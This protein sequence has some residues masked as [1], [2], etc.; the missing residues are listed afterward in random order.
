MATPTLPP[1]PRPS[2]LG[3]SDVCLSQPRPAD[4]GVGEG[5]WGVGR[6]V[7]EGGVVNVLLTDLSWSCVRLPLGPRVNEEESEEEE[8]EEERERE[9]VQTQ[10][11]LYYYYYYYICLS[12]Y[13]KHY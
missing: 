8:E 9:K 7:G 6:E 4:L 12:F 3:G 5:W 13:S 2:K 1:P 10:I 11:W